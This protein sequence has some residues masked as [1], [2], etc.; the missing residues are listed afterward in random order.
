MRKAATVTAIMEQMR[1]SYYQVDPQRREIIYAR[2]EDNV[3][4]RYRIGS[5]KDDQHRWLEA[6]NQLCII[7][8]PRIDSRG[9]SRT[10]PRGASLLLSSPDYGGERLIPRDTRP[11]GFS[12]PHGLTLR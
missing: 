1:L 4:R 9:A 10:R 3:F 11:D 7:P 6:L 8:L 5:R 2:R 12:V